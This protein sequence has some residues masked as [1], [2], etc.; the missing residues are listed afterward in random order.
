MITKKGIDVLQRI[1]ILSVLLIT[2]PYYCVASERPG[3]TTPDE[4]YHID[5]G[6]TITHAVCST[7]NGKKTYTVTKYAFSHCDDSF[8]GKVKDTFGTVDVLLPVGRTKTTEQA[9]LKAKEQHR[10][11]FLK[12]KKNSVIYRKGIKKP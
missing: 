10:R 12:T 8:L 7:I 9:F 11:F 3:T 2:V 6:K 4:I 5:K 1:C